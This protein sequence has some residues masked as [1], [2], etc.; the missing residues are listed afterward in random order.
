MKIEYLDTYRFNRQIND[1]KKLYFED[2]VSMT[3]TRTRHT[4]CLYYCMI[5]N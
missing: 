3:S 4:Y 2:L 5:G 1:T